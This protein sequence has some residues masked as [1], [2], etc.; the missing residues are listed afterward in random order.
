MIPKPAY[1]TKDLIETIKTS[2]LEDLK[3]ISELVLL[4]AARYS[5]K[6]LKKIQDNIGL[7]IAYIGISMI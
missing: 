6:D 3:V 5:M 7:R 1:K 4:E 2:S